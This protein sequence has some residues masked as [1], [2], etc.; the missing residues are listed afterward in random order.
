MGKRLDTITTYAKGA[1]EF[2]QALA[3][4]NQAAS[5]RMTELHAVRPTPIRRTTTGNSSAF[6]PMV[7]LRPTKTLDIPVTLQD[8]LRRVGVPFSQDSIEA[9]QDSVTHA[10]LERD[11][12][13]REHYDSTST[14]AHELLA[15]RSSKA[16]S[17][18][19]VILDALYKHTLFQQVRLTDANMDEQRKSI[20]R[21]LEDKDGELLEAE[22]NELRL[23]DPQVRS[24]IAKYGR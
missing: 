13:L 1:D 14:S 5:E 6:T 7:K 24:F 16:D 2:Q 4:V 19:R 10:Q 15:E 8:A 18:A 12:K 20:E 11:R 23:S 21:D 3:H 22:G 17:D 9:L